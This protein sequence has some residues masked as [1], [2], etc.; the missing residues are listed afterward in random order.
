M[1]EL[2]YSTIISDVSEVCITDCPYNKDIKIGSDE[3]KNCQYFHSDNFL[4]KKIKCN[5]KEEL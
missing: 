2:D 3:C 5:K 4:A 1:K